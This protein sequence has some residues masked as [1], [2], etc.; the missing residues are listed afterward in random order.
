MT[1][2]SKSDFWSAL[3]GQ[4]FVAARL[5]GPQVQSG[6]KPPHSKTGC[7]TSITPPVAGC[8]FTAMPMNSQI[9]RP[10][11]TTTFNSTM[12]IRESTAPQAMCAAESCALRRWRST[13]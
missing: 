12:S 10:R 13:A 1:A 5:D 11:V 4:R 3:A 9:D 2:A 6:V 8:Y 7:L